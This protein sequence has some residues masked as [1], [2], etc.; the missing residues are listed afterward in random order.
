MKM[1][2]IP[3]EKICKICKEKKLLNQFEINNRTKDRHATTCKDCSAKNQP[4]ICTCTCEKC[5]DGRIMKTAFSSMELL[6]SRMENGR[7]KLPD[8]M[9]MMITSLAYS[10][11]ILCEN[12]EKELAD[13]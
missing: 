13:K 5:V 10:A 11:G 8:E 3:I 7:L 9:L 1:E 12:C 4:S 2:P 6:L